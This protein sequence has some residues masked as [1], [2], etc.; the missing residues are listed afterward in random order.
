MFEKMARYPTP[1]EL[2]FQSLC[3]FILFL[4]ISKIQKKECELI[5]H[6]L[7]KIHLIMNYSPKSPE[8]SV[9]KLGDWNVKN[10]DNQ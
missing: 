1:G 5:I 4:F 7:R 10:N 6:D 9:H 3:L 8:H 2:I